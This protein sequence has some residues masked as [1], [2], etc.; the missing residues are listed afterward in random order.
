VAVI[1][2]DGNKFR[3]PVD[4]VRFTSGLLKALSSKK[5]SKESIENIRKSKIGQKASIQTKEKLSTL[6]KGSGNPRY[7]AILTKDTKNKISVTLKNAPLVYCPH[8]NFSCRSMGAMKRH[9]FDNCKI[10]V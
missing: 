8:C 2:V 5:R 3:V 7:G 6:R 4:D 1:D 9:H 10:K